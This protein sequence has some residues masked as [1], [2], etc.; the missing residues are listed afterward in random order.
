MTEVGIGC[1]VTEGDMG[2]IEVNPSVLLVGITLPVPLVSKGS[3]KYRMGRNVTCSLENVVPFQS[4]LVP[5]R[6][7]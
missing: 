5:R 1:W 4:G 6:V 2:I 3:Q 7:N